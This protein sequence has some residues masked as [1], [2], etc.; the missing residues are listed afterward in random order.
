M[1]GA[2]DLVERGLLRHAGP[3]DDYALLSL[4][5]G[6]AAL[7]HPSR[8]EG[9]GLTVLEAMALGVPVLAARCPAVEE[10]AGDTA[11]WL[12]PGDADA[13]AD[14]LVEI[15]ASP[16]PPEEERSRCRESALR[17][18]WRD[19]AAALLGAI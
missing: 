18:R 9:F 15:A 4:Y 3:L 17:F 19:G 11:R 14:A 8:Y 10:V 13:W 12:P 6:A 16:P 2:G 5:A 7:L 1:S